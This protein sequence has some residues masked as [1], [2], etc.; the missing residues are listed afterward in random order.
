M[1]QY[2]PHETTLTGEEAERD[3][4]LARQT[5]TAFTELVASNLAHWIASRDS[6]GRVNRDQIQNSQM[7]Q[8]TNFM[9]EHSPHFSMLHHIQREQ[10]VSL[11]AESWAGNEEILDQM[12]VGALIE[13]EIA[14]LDPAVEAFE[15]RR[16]LTT[17]SKEARF[18]KRG[19]EGAVTRRKIYE[20]PFYSS[21]LDELHR[22]SKKKNGVG[23]VILYGPPGTGKTE[24]LQQK[25]TEEGYETHVVSIHHYTS[26]A[27]LLADRSI[28]LRGDL[29]AQRAQG[30]EVPINYFKDKTPEEFSKVMTIIFDDLKAGGRA[31]E[32]QQISQ[33]LLPYLALDQ[34]GIVDILA[35]DQLS[36]DDWRYIQNAF[37]TK[38]ES[39]LLRTS[40]SAQHQE[41]LEEDV[42]RGEILLAIKKS[43]GTDRKIRVL[44]D[45]IDK[46]G[47]NSL[48][49][50]LTFLSKSP[51]ESI[52]IGETRE[53][54]PSWFLVDATSNSPD[55]N[56][57]FLDRFSHLRV[58]TPPTKDQL[59]IAGVKV[60]DDEGNILLSPYEQEQLGSFFV[61]VLPNINALLTREDHNWP[62]ISNRGI[63]ELTSYL[64]D[65]RNMKRTDLSVNEAVNKLLLQN[66]IWSADA[67]LAED[68]GKVLDS[69]SD[70]LGDEPVAIKRLNRPDAHSADRDER[71]EDALDA[72]INSPLISMINGLVEQP[73]GGRIHLQEV[74]LTPEQQQLVAKYLEDEQGKVR[75]SLDVLNLPIGLTYYIKTDG[76]GE[77]LQLVA[78]PPDRKIHILHEQRILHGGSLDGASADGK[79][80]VMSSEDKGSDSELRVINPFNTDEKSHQNNLPKRAK[81]VI[82]KTG[83]YIGYL[84]S[85][86]TL[87]VRSDN[88]Q[89]LNHLS[90]V[91]DFQFSGDGKQILVK[92]LG[93]EF[94]LYSPSTLKPIMEESLD[95]PEQGFEWKFIGDHVLAQVSQNAGDRP[96]EIALYVS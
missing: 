59:M 53:E 54:I 43:K 49:G 36:P 15:L 44:L 65:F 4:V 85:D 12:L 60:C 8:M 81:P 64:V 96:K 42:V 18:G 69:Y 58:N 16:W 78:V 71:Y 57:Y 88:M 20:T 84:S 61:Y 67:G 93:G 80:I 74:R 46:A 63:Q 1:A 56:E 27:E 75:G 25:N 76:E 33:F 52:V 70:I 86:H 50:I 95:R 40:L 39:R 28:A 45:E 79:T 77:K 89:R 68:I 51:G 23:G 19:P 7:V 55:I 11:S 30:L 6:F 66:K 73:K 94:W 24:V 5:R 90:G 35:K 9:L 14:R 21:L 37:I 34:A 31:G 10:G 3:N 29:G 2:L 22:L 48:G 91:E 87:S 82:D 92:R 17:T 62:P 38:Q 26:F 83:N 72:T 41:T 47:P 32:D 13:E